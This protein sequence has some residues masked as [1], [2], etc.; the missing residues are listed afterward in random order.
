M[1]RFL[2]YRRAKFTLVFFGIQIVFDHKVTPARR[3]PGT[4][5]AVAPF[6]IELWVVGIWVFKRR[7]F[8]FGLLC[9]SL[10]FRVLPQ[11]FNGVIGLL[12]AIGLTQ[13]RIR[14]TFNAFFVNR[15]KF[16]IMGLLQNVVR[17]FAKW[18]VVGFFKPSWF[19]RLTFPGGFTF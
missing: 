15:C 10:C 19:R 2:A 5:K 7:F 18:V 4:S 6:L 1:E 12:F 13:K 8:A 9:L 16:A 3:V 14:I 11:F 17:G